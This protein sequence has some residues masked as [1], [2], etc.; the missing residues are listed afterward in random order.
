MKNIF[1]GEYLKN[2]YFCGNQEK[3]NYDIG[4]SILQT[5]SLESLR[6]PFQFSKLKVEKRNLGLM[7]YDMDYSHLDN[8]QPTFFR[9]VMS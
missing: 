3:K 6:S 7:L 4:I 5:L 8:I 1:A 2:G 9:A